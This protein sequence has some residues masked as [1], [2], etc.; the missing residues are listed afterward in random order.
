MNYNEGTYLIMV[1][2]FIAYFYFII[3]KYG[4]LTSISESFYELE[5]SKEGMGRIFTAWISLLGV[6]VMVCC[7]HTLAVIAGGGMILVG[8]APYFKSKLGKWPHYIGAGIA[9]LC[10]QLYIGLVLPSIYIFLIIYFLTIAIS[11]VIDRKASPKWLWRLE[12]QAF[13]TFFLA[14]GIYLFLK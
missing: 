8:A 14:Q 1:G 2:L 12:A 11:L 6:G 4:R 5:E 7:E 9:I 10:I 13:F 3:V